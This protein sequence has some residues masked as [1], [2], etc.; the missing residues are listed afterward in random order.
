MSIS[1]K[2]VRDKTW[3]RRIIK[4]RV[5]I[6]NNEI[7]K[8]RSKWQAITARVETL[9]P[10]DAKAWYKQIKKEELEWAWI[11]K[12]EELQKKLNYQIPEPADTLDGIPIGE[13]ILRETHGDTIEEGII[14]GG[15]QASREVKAFLRLPS[16]FRVYEKFDEQRFRVHSEVTSTKQRFSRLADKGDSLNND[17]RLDIR[18]TETRARNVMRQGGTEADFTMMKAKDLKHHKRMGQPECLPEEEEIKVLN[19][20]RISLEAMGA[21]LGDNES[22]PK[23]G[24]NLTKEEYLGWKEVKS[25]IKSKGWHLCA[26]DKSGKLVLDLKDNYL[27]AMLKHANK[28]VPASMEEVAISE[29]ILY[30]HST[31]ICRIFNMGREAGDGEADRIKEALKPVFCGVPALVGSRK[32]H[33]TGW[34]AIIGPPT[35]PICNANI[36][37]NSG[38]G[39]LVARALRPLKIALGR[40]CQYTVCS[41]EELLREIHDYNQSTLEA[42]EP[43]LP[44]SQ[45]ILVPQSQEPQEPHRRVRACKDM[46]DTSVIIGSMDVCALYPSCKIKETQEHIRKAFSKGAI[47]YIPQ[48]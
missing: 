33:K 30:S 5:K 1:L 2:N 25:G 47:D 26:T 38:L 24:C 11:H 8:Q 40:E 16:K 37:P 36:G 27:Q 48:Q 10:R 35:R 20:K 42:Q 12:K 6:K 17:A 21:Y 4:D 45:E 43:L 41:T 19:Q 14:L 3:E 44:Q 31:A 15:I 18:D 7:A 46:Q 34:D 13:S 28:D 22:Q 32:D 39:N 23:T 29:G 9:L